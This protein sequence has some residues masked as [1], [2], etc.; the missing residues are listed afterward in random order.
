[1]MVPRSGAGYGLPST[2]LAPQAPGWLAWSQLLCCKVLA[3]AVLVGLA[4]PPSWARSQATAHRSF[5]I[6]AD[7]GTNR[8]D[9]SFRIRANLN[10]T[11]AARNYRVSC[12]EANIAWPPAGSW[13]Q[14]YDNLAFDVDIT[15]YP[16]SNWLPL[17]LYAD[18]QLVGMQI[19]ATPAPQHVGQFRARTLW[20]FPGPRDLTLRVLTPEGPVDMVGNSTLPDQGL[21]PDVKVHNLQFWNLTDPFA[22]VAVPAGQV[23]PVV[24]RVNDYLYSHLN[25]DSID[26]IFGQCPTDT[27]TQ[28]RY[29]GLDNMTINANCV[30]MTTWSGNS[31]NCGTLYQTCINAIFG[32]VIAA[33]PTLELIHIVFVDNYGSNLC[34]NAGSGG[35]HRLVTDY[36]G[37]DPDP[38]NH[39]YMIL[40]EDQFPSNPDAFARLL[41]HEV[42]H[43]YL[44]GHTNN[45][46]PCP[47][48]PLSR[49]LRC[50][51]T[52]RL[53]NAGQCQNAANNTNLRYQDQND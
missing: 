51:N 32:Q 48:N 2:S 37:S 52:G 11:E 38:A 8:D 45:G 27:H 13:N 16:G 17:L 26:A 25:D 28:F 30:D 14:S 10:S 19:I 46:D 42:G 6:D 9:C 31:N 29:A 1:M 33:D 34:S 23:R 7:R 35:T 20:P 41:A 18:A 22:T 24:D 39:G 53:I 15:N 12:P 5:S 49:N 36:D 47:G 43:T 50:S 44:G 4:L 3:L 40:I 21:L